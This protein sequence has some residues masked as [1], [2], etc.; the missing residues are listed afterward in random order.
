MIHKERNLLKTGDAA[1][2]ECD[3]NK[4]HLLHH[5]WSGASGGQVRTEGA[6]NKGGEEG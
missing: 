2:G 1:C 6:E 4:F 5:I 3:D